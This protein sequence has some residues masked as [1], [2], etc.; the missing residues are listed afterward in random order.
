MS[1]IR[2]PIFSF[3]DGQLDVF[4][5]AHDAILKAEAID[6]EDGAWEPI[7]DSEGKRLEMTVVGPRDKQGRPT[8][9]CRVQIEI[10]E[11]IPA[12]VE[13]FC[14]LLRDRLKAYGSSFA[15][16]EKADFEA[17]QEEAIR[18]CGFTR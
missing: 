9:A 16:N 18:L 12:Q 10:A 1:N 8:A 4:K 6:V 13:R 14:S 2:P 3:G 11:S 17:L 5:N 15:S 7:F